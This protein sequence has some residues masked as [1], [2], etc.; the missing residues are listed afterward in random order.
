LY[1]KPKI[2]LIPGVHGGQE[3]IKVLFANDRKIANVLERETPARWSS[4]LGYWYIFKEKF[5]LGDFFTIMKTVAYIDYS[6]LTNKSGQKSK[7][8]NT[9]KK[10]SAMCIKNQLP[11]TSKIKIES[12]KLWMRQLRFSDN[13]IKTYIHQLQLFFGYYSGKKPEEITPADIEF[14][15][16]NFILKNGLSPTFQNQTISALKKFYINQYNRNLDTENIICPVKS[17]TLPKVINKKDLK[18]FFESIKNVKHRMAFETIYAYGLRRS[19]LLNLKL[20]DI[21]TRRGIISIINGKGKKDRSLPI[22]KRWLE[23][24]KPYYRTYRPGVYLIEG[25]CPGK[26]ISAGSLQKVFERALKES[27]ITRP[28]TIHCLR[29][30]FATHLLENGTD[31]RY[32]QELLG[33]KSSRTT[34]IYT[35]VSNESLRNIKNPF[36]DMEL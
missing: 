25:Q 26:S 19:E 31:L 14:F 20:Q 8:I 3:I 18:R 6:G 13:T 12:F 15:N 36:D 22:S 32:I 27:K 28:Y 16:L 11:R 23:K 5:N 9:E 24:V 29:H 1:S 34:E 17:R 2:K 30:S 33:H 21:D 10:Y 7:S 35:H 4:H